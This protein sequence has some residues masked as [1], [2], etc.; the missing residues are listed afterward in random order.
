MVGAQLLA[1]GGL[2]VLLDGKRH[3]VRKLEPQIDGRRQNLFDQAGKRFYSSKEP[4]SWQA[5]PVLY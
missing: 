5:G 1:D 3:S 2:L 4:N